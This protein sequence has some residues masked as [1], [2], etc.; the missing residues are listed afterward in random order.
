ME[1]AKKGNQGEYMAFYSIAFSMAH[2]FG[3]KASMQMVNDWGFDNTWYMVTTI[4]AF[5]VIL[6]LILKSHLNLKVKLLK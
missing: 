6:L 5:C 4:G 3:H 2:I 1:W